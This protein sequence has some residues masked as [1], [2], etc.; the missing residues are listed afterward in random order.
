MPSP[1]TTKPVVHKL[2]WCRLCK[3][4]LTCRRTP[5]TIFGTGHCKCPEQELRHNAKL[6]KQN[7]TTDFRCRHISSTE[8]LGMQWLVAINNLPVNP[9]ESNIVR[10]NMCGT[11]QQRSRRAQEYD[12]VPHVVDGLPIP[13]DFRRNRSIVATIRESQNRAMTRST[14]TNLVVPEESDSQPLHAAEVTTPAHRSPELDAILSAPPIFTRQNSTPPSLP[15]PLPLMTVESPETPLNYLRRV[16]RTRTTP[17]SSSSPIL[18]RNIQTQ[19]FDASNTCII[20]AA[21]TENMTLSELLYTHCPSAPKRLLFRNMV[22]GDLVSR[23]CTLVGIEANDDNVVVIKASEPQDGP[24]A[25]WQVSPI[26]SA[27]PPPPSLLRWVSNDSPDRGSR[28]A[29][30]FA[31]TTHTYGDQYASA[32]PD[33]RMSFANILGDR[34]DN[35]SRCRFGI[36]DHFR[37]LPSLLNQRYNP[38]SRQHVESSSRARLSSQ[39]R[40]ILPQRTPTQPGGSFEE[41]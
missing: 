8:V 24:P 7:Q 16:P 23:S 35:I 20:Y 17:D 37:Q 33:F 5:R 2:N 13:S 4:C 31:H 14:V 11:C 34:E 27:P 9:I 21:A 39:D 3:V 26:F 22:T 15:L 38:Y 1:D 36:A 28:Q 30:E 18:Y 6:V 32:I 40:D 25:Q 41:R 19:V 10:A 29:A 12:N